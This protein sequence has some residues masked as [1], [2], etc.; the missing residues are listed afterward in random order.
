MSNVG[1]VD[2]TLP[3]WGVL[4]R[5]FTLGIV[6]GGSKVILQVLNTLHVKGEESF[7]SQVF[8]RQPGTPLFTVS[9]HI[10]S[11]SLHAGAMLFVFLAA[12]TIT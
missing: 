11:A 12:S 9:N 10:R 7:R 6:S 1:E 2:Y 4:G 3:P 8:N 5:D